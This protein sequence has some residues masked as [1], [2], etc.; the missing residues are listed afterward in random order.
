MKLVRLLL[1]G[2]VA[3]A[4]AAFADTPPS[5]GQAPIQN[6]TIDAKAGTTCVIIVKHGSVDSYGGCMFESGSIG[7]TPSFGI[8][9]GPATLQNIP[10]QGQ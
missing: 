5:T 6:A 9:Y 7:I 4:P 3:F 10:L 8:T 1:V 2:A